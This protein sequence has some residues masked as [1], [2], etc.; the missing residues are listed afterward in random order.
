MKR[1]KRKCRRR[2]LLRERERGLQEVQV[3]GCARGGGMRVTLWGEGGHSALPPHAKGLQHCDQNQSTS[4]L[5]IRRKEAFSVTTLLQA[6]VTLLGG[7]VGGGQEG[8]CEGFRWQADWSG[9]G[10][11]RGLKRALF[12][13]RPSP[14]LIL[15]TTLLFP[16]RLL[17]F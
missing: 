14:A 2:E 5:Y 17:P 12:L 8:E 7:G 11:K 3:R 16:G 6:E 13:L 15:F 10:A 9:R 4:S 1:R